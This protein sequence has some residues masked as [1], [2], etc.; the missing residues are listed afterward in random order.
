MWDKVKV[1]YQKMVNSRLGKVIT[2]YIHTEN[3]N[4]LAETI[5]THALFKTVGECSLKR[6]GNKAGKN[7]ST[8][9]L[10]LVVLIM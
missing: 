7:F 3:V 6:K 1:K 8:N 2:E 9:C 4:M 5:L 10:E